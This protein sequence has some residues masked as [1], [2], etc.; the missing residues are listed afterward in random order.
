MK[1]LFIL[2]LFFISTFIYSND[3]RTELFIGVNI[4]Y[5][6]KIE[7][8]NQTNQNTFF[9]TLG[10]SV[11]STDY[12]CFTPNIGFFHNYYS[13]YKDTPYIVG[14]ENR[15]GESYNILVNLPVEYKLVLNPMHSFQIGLGPSVFLRL[16]SLLY[17]TSAIEKFNNYVWQN[18][19]FLYANAKLSYLYKMNNEV[20]IGPEVQ[21]YIPLYSVL[22]EKSFSDGIISIGI[23]FK[24]L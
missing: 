18:A 3:K 11:I 17:S 5:P 12:F 19:R 23:K 15:K 4:I 7:A 2:I 6:P 1:K 21:V 20:Q 16:S 22:K 14:A 24:A 10:Y 8:I 9:A 13:F